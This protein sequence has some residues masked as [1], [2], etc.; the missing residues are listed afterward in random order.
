M[1]VTEEQFAAAKLKDARAKIVTVTVNDE[2]FDFVVRPA[3]R[4]EWKVYKSV[5][6]DPNPDRSA[7]A[8]EALLIDTALCPTGHDLILALDKIPAAADVIA[9]KI[10]TL[11]GLVQDA[12][13]GESI[14]S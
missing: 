12:Q 13:V 5:A 2:A 6:N 1:K 8:N 14:R 9:G 11:S 3:T 7:C 10:K 4:A